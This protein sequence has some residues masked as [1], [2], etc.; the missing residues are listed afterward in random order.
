MLQVSAGQEGTFTVNGEPGG[1]PEKGT[2]SKV[3]RDGKQRLTAV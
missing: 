1:L 2:A 3:G